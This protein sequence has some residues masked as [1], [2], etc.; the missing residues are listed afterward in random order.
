MYSYTT[1]T[2]IYR[3]WC[4]L[5]RSIHEVLVSRPR[6]QR[7]LGRARRYHNSTIP[8][9]D[10]RSSHWASRFSYTEDQNGSRESNAEDSSRLDERVR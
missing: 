6:P 4:Y 8:P 2:S 3:E 9:L 1:Y 5:W 7:I 10:F